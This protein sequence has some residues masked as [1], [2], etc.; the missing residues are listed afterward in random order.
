MARHDLLIIGSGPGGYTAAIRAA[1]LGMNVAI[2][3]EHDVSGGTCLRVGCI[4]SKALLES[5]EL[6]AKVA[7]ELGDHGISVEG[8]TLDLAQMQKRKDRIVQILTRGINSL[9]RKNG[10]VRYVGRARL[11]GSGKVLVS[12][13]DEKLTVE[14]ARIMIA[15]GSKPATLPGI[16]MT[17]GV[18][19]TSTEAL[20]YSEVPQRL[21]VVGAGYIG[22]EIGSI[23][24]RLGSEVTVLEYLDRIMPGLDREL[25][26][27]AQRELAR[28]GIQFHLGA[29]VVAA[30]RSEDGS[31]QVSVD[32]GSDVE[33]DR[34]LVAVGRRPNTEGLGLESVGIKTKSD[35]A[36]PVGRD[37]QTEAEGVYAVGDVI[38]GAMLAHKAEKEGIACVEG[39]AGES[40]QV[41]YDAIPSV[42][43][44]HP[45]VASVGAS[46]EEL[47]D[48]KV[49]YRVGRFPFRANGR[50]RALGDESGWVKVLAHETTDR[51]LGVHIIGPRAG[52]LIAEA[53][54]AMEFSASSE[55]VTH[56]THAHP[57]LSEALKEAALAVYDRAIHI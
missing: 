6:Y 56:V 47:K 9:F 21:A 29:R 24:R 5:S 41:R 49:P 2:V 26:D 18:A 30:T 25:A 14:A 4:P 16:S 32:G 34:L 40:V 31:I 13:D 46:E 48:Q 45:E 28:Q 8:A 33:C 38:G 11:D 15:T 36:I 53:A 43:Y 22:L 27:E 1:Q 23:W 10:I 17:D 37:F 20:S 7:E 42:A 3:D 44:I 19:S 39:M 12:K 55:D 51:L 52:D 35:G 54:T 50:A 57:T